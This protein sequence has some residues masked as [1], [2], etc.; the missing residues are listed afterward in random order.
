MTPAQK[1]WLKQAKALLAAIP[2]GCWVYQ[3]S[4]GLSLM[5]YGENGKVVTTPMS[6][7]DPQCE[8]G[9]ASAPAGKWI[10]GGDW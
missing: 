5:E 1:A 4:N 3:N 2:D 6:G 8:I 10:D 9:K 7:M